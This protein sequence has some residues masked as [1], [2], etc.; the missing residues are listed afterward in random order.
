MRF[1]EVENQITI[2]EQWANSQVILN[3]V[4]YAGMKDANSD[5]VLKKLGAKILS[6]AIDKF[7]KTDEMS[8]KDAQ[9]EI[10]RLQGM[11]ST[12]KD[13]KQGTISKFIDFFRKNPKLIGLGVIILLLISP[14]LPK[15]AI[16]GLSL[17]KII[18][19]VLSGLYTIDIASPMVKTHIEM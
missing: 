2:L 6:K 14:L 18:T 11:L 19:I 17:E 12:Q 3:E 9:K 13:V 5:G 16:I 10:D 1:S 7:E 15:I 8:P 4:E